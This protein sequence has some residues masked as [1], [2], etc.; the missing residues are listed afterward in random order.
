LRIRKSETPRRF[1]P[2]LS[3][4]HEVLALGGI[5]A[6]SLYPDPKHSFYKWIRLA[7]VYTGRVLKVTGD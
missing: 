1:G 2:S 5:S 7:Q 3:E 4:S 6:M